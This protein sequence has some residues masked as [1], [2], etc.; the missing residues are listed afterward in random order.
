M[1]A[2]QNY[3]A[4]DLGAESGRAILGQFNGERFQLS[5]E[6]RFPNIPVSVPQKFG[7]TSLRWDVLRLWSEVKEGIAKVTRKQGETL[8]AIGVDTWGVDFGLFDEKGA[9]IA[10]PYAYR[11]NRTDGMMEKA[12]ERVSQEQIFE[13]SGIQFLQL[14]SLYQMLAMVLDN[15]SELRI[16]KTFLTMPDI[17]NYWLTGDMVSEFTIATTTQCYNPRKRKW[18]Y[19]L[20]EAMG[21]PNYIF[22]EIV[23]AGTY[24]GKIVK[25]LAEELNTKASI[26]APACHDT[27]SAAA[28]VPS[29]HDNIAWISSGTWSILGTNVTDPV[30]NKQSL[31]HNFTNEGGVDNTFRFCKNIS[32]LWLVQECRRAWALEGQEF[33]Y[34]ELTDLASLAKPLVSFVNSD[35]PEFLHPGGM[36]ERIANYCRRTGQPIPD[37]KAAFLRC[38]LESIALKYR[39]VLENLEQILGKTLDPIHIVGGGTKN[40]LLNQFTADATGKHVISGPAE[41][42]ALGNI[43]MQAVALGNIASIQQGREII[44]KSCDVSTYEPGDKNPWD[45]AYGRFIELVEK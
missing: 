31:A 27:G 17:I 5:E 24:L 18:A 39:Y 45:V 32:G 9:L 10:S 29:T 21:I 28:A 1:T 4:L 8:T 36:P 2:T 3:L 15:A 38:A 42:T 34:T 11:D 43:M 19:P 14:N 35:D 26:I 13:Q 7:A 44:R 23:S 25:T 22:P 37:S 20:I 16:A 6:H 41:A 33:T 12:F 40:K 30:I